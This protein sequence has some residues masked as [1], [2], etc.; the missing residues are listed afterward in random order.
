MVEAILVDTIK[1][2]DTEME[3][4]RAF[5]HYNDKWNGVFV[6]TALLFL[7]PHD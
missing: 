6:E 3:I 5:T 1:A 4:K 7:E 2:K